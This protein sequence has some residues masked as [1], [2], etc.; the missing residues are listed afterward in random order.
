M[1][2]F[3]AVSSLI[4]KQKLVYLTTSTGESL[5]NENG[6]VSLSAIDFLFN[7][8]H[9]RDN[10][11]NI[12][13]ICYA[14][15]RDN[16]FIFSGLPDELKDKLFQSR[17]YQDTLEQLEYEQEQIKLERYISKDI[18][19]LQFLD[20]SEYVNDSFLRDFQNVRYSNFNLTL[21]NGKFLTVRAGKKSITIYDV[22]GF[23]R[24]PIYDAVREWLKEDVSLLNRE[25]PVKNLEVLKIQTELETNYIC[26]LTE[27][28]NKQLNQ[29]G[30]TLSRFHGASALSSR[31]LSLSG[32]KKEF[33]AYKNQ[34]QTSNEC[35]KASQQAFHGAR[36][37]Q[38]K[39]GTLKDINVYDINSAYAFSCLFL[40]QILR[41]PIFTKE[42]NRETFSLWYAD[43]DFSGCD[44]YFGLLPNRAKIGNFATYPLKGK[45]YFY[46]P[47]IEFILQYYPDCIKIKQ[48]FYLPFVES[49]WT[50]YILTIY[51]LRKKLKKQGNPLEKV[52]KLALA[53]IYGKFCQ[54]QGRAYFYNFYYAGFITAKVRA[55]LLQ[56]THKAQ[57]KTICFLTDAIH[58]TSLL[59]VSVSDEIGDFR[60]K[61]YE[62]GTYFNAGVYQLTDKE[63]NKK[64]AHQGFNSFNFD[65]ALAD[66]RTDKVYQGLQELFTGWN[67]YTD[68]LFRSAE[69][70]S[71]YSQDKKTNPFETGARLFDTLKVDLSENY[72]DSQVLKHYSML[73]SGLYKESRYKE[74]NLALDTIRA[75]RL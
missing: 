66:L 61:Q 9:K 54:R 45:G 15:S 44:F 3:V 57:E 75:K 47:E 13:F 41:K 16:E 55:M 64:L 56:A 10:K 50:K 53:G 60:L 69:Y 62:R 73:E 18:N 11:A 8:H 25:L 46:Q 37:E 2:K 19:R 29:F 70:L 32:A 43:Y 7:L 65:K 40:P 5:F 38:Y 74:S 42:Y 34:H 71:H 24:K 72:I 51:E 31:I 26:E 17:K 39:I 4:Y 35:Y 59:P 12:V 33:Y 58:S 30:L 49:N 23:F 27:K 67:V 21:V 14:F 6:I 20:F 48:G 28:L 68:K 52:L 22:Y 1:K 36:I 63:G